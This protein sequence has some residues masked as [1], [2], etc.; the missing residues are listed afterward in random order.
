MCETCLVSF[1]WIFPHV[2]RIHVILRITVILFFILGKHSKNIPEKLGVLVIDN[3]LPKL[4]VT[5]DI[6]HGVC[7]VLNCAPREGF[8]EAIC[9]TRVKFQVQKV[10]DGRLA[11]GAS[12]V[13]S[14]NHGS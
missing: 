11:Y 13:L 5:Y 3:F 4:L 14:N 7:G 6:K 10:C 9:F 1:C 8:H 2:T 12:N